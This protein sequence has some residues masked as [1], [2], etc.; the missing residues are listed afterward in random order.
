MSVNRV[1]ESPASLPEQSVTPPS[2]A[3]GKYEEV[4]LQKHGQEFVDKAKG[5]A[6]QLGVKPEWLFAVMQNESG[7]NPATMNKNS[8]ATALIQLKALK[9]M[10]AAQQLDY[11]ARFYAPFAGKMKTGA[12][13]YMATFYPLALSKGADFVLGSERSPQWVARIAHDNPAFDLDKDGQI[14]KGE[15]LQYYNKRFPELAS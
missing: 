12:D 8:G 7:L 5:I 1:G 4:A 3:A 11:V 15:F 2:Y 10:S 9:D 6:S 13:L 14:S